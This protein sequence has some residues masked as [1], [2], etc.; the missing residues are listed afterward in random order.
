MF[1]SDLLADVALLHALSAKVAAAVNSETCGAVAVE[2]L[3]EVLAGGRQID[4]ATTRLIERADRTGEYAADG[5]ASISAYVRITANENPGWATRRVHIGRGL[6]DRLPATLAAF[7]TG[8]LGLE[9]ANVIDQATKKLTDPELITSLDTYL[10]LLAATM[11]PHDL[12]AASQDLKSQAEPEETAK[13]NAKKRAAQSLHISETIDGMYRLDGW[14]DAESGAIFLAGLGAFVRKPVPGGDLLTE[15]L[16]RRRADALIDIARQAL[17]HTERCQGQSMS[18]HTLIVGLTHQQLLDALGTAA[19]S[20]GTHLPAAARRLA[21]EADIIPVVYGA[22]S[23]IVD[24]GR[25]RRLASDGLRR[26]INLRDGG[27][28]FPHCDRPPQMTETHHRD[29]WARHHGKTDILTLESLC[30][31]HHHLVHEGGWTITIAD[32]PTRTP[33]FHPPNGKPPQQGKRQGL[34][35][36]GDYPQRT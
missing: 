19:V 15:S 7:Q 14:L 5:A 1:D 20:D 22:D 23:E 4:L 26:S 34:L 29:E 28:I 17:T 21:C 35:H 6:A 31:H 36:R 12:A 16:T 27:C 10:A 33:W 25:A 9:H 13:E 32:N 8:Q 2:A 24:Y 18:R 11:T 3:A 30:R